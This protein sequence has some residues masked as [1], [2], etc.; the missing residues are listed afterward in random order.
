MITLGDVVVS[1]APTGG[2]V[3]TFVSPL[4]TETPHPSL[5]MAHS[6]SLLSGPSRCGPYRIQVLDRTVSLLQV[7]SSSPIPLPLTEIADRAR[8]H[9][10]TAQR[11]LRI[12][13]S[14]G[15]VHRRNDG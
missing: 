10:S 15:L 12:L 5:F 2:P 1:H 3:S 9:K 8:L 13:Q 6:E 4:A 11:F 14:Y 7:L